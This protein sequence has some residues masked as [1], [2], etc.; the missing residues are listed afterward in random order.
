MPKKKLKDIEVVEGPSTDAQD[1][2]KASEE[3]VAAEVAPEDKKELEEALEGN[4]ST[5]PQDGA[6]APEDSTDREQAEESQE[7]ELV[8]EVKEHKSVKPNVKK[9]PHGKKYMNVA[10]LVDKT[11]EYEL[12]EAIEVLKKTATTKFDS[13][14][15]IHVN[16]NVDLTNPD[17]QV[18]GSV[19]LP[20]GIGKE[21]KVAVVCGP[22]KAKEAK[23]A[24][25]EEVG[26]QELIEKIEKGWLGF[27]VL[28]ASPDMMG[29][30][31]KLGKILGTKGLMPNPKTGTVSPEVGK[32]VTE[33]KKGKAD[34]RVDKG[35]VIHASVGKV[36][37]KEA[38][39][40][41]NVEAFMDAIHHAKPGSVKGTFIKSVHLSTTMGPGVKLA[42][43]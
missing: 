3:V 30:L 18:R 26:G 40:V 39:L 9:H 13:S 25:A 41:T 7:P 4:P 38:D 35:G 17:Q 20:A 34:Y 11:K 10:K 36:S 32:A 27:D 1:D 21:K 14:V 15:E 8:E 33:I 19:S 31:A 37:F 28:V 43:K 16:L 24:G 12:A 5:S 42:D 23:D 29:Q 6:A 22:D 2:A